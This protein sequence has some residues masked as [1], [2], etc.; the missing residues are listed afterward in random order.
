[1]ENTSYVLSFLT[2]GAVFS[3][4]IFLF[5]FKSFDADVFSAMISFTGLLLALYSANR[6]LKAKANEKVVSHLMG[7]IDD[8]QN[9]IT[10]IM[11]NNEVF[12]NL[13]NR[14]LVE[15]QKANNI[16]D[17]MDEFKKDLNDTIIRLKLLRLKL[18]F[19][20]FWGGESKSLILDLEVIIDLLD[21]Y[22]ITR[23]NHAILLLQGNV[24][25]AKAE[26]F[27]KF[28]VLIRHEL[29]KMISGGYRYYLKLMN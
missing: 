21:S 23:N 2:G 17:K 20:E 14:Y 13:L 28:I 25:K 24:N 15:G 12:K 3:M 11:Y 9:E 7:A 5:S 10:R 16:I 26:N 8:I 4:V 6:W 27:E 19:C 18:N 1:M 29:E 22:C